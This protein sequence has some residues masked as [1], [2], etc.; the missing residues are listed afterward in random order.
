MPLLLLSSNFHVFPKE[1]KK[2]SPHPTALSR[3][4]PSCSR[5]HCRQ[6]WISQKSETS[7]E[8]A[9]PAL[10]TSMVVRMLTMPTTSDD[11]H[12]FVKV[13]GCYSYIGPT[14][15]SYTLWKA[16]GT[17][18]IG[19]SLTPAPTQLDSGCALKFD[20]KIFC[21]SQNFQTLQIPWQWWIL[22]VER[23]IWPPSANYCP[24][25]SKLTLDTPPFN[26]SK[27]VPP[28]RS[29]P[30]ATWPRRKRLADGG[31]ADGAR[32]SATNDEQVNHGKIDANHKSRFVLLGIHINCQV[33]W[34]VLGN[35][36]QVRS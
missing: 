20:K 4:L 26:L 28:T 5:S 16:H 13:S 8:N 6:T 32:V 15:L 17:V 11:G 31:V 34:G 3:P 10:R 18:A 30:W 1:P 9:F 33:V 12:I 22:C 29:W 21:V 35:V 7:H 27:R 23:L 14:N 24:T 2:N 36:N 19:L 25:M